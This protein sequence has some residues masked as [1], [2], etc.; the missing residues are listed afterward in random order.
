MEEGKILVTGGAGYIGSHAVRQLVKSGFQVVVVD[1]LS[2]GH[3]DAVDPKA[4]FV[5][6]DVRNLGLLDAIFI[7]ITQRMA[8]G[9]RNN[10]FAG[11][12]HNADNLVFGE[13]SI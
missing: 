1:N 11:K 7:K 9:F 4:E 6:G 13:D 2:T 5:Y 12:L 8:N 10:D 3:L